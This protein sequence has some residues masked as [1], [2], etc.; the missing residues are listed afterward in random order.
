MDKNDLY[1]LSQSSTKCD[2]YSRMAH[3][4]SFQSLWRLRYRMLYMTT[5]Q[6]TFP[7]SYSSGSADDP[8]SALNRSTWTGLGRQKTEVELLFLLFLP[9][10]S[11]GGHILFFAWAVIEIS[12]SR[13]YFDGYEG[14][15][16]EDILLTQITE[17]LIPEPAVITHSQLPDWR[18]GISPSWRHFGGG[19]GT[20]ESSAE[21]LPLWRSQ[22][23]GE[24]FMFEWNRILLTRARVV[25]LF[26]S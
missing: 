4:A 23:L 15:W 5:F 9:L 13:P 12:A 18:R 20:S 24:P 19:A 3:C 10:S 22:W 1:Q 7:D 14:Q 11:S 26:C 17:E 6:A 2:S 8:V 21:S 16:K 25:S